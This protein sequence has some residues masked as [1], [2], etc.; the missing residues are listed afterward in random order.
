LHYHPLD[1][2]FIETANCESQFHS[3]H[4]LKCALLLATWQRTSAVEETWSQVC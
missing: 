1:A 4:G 3:L 2:F